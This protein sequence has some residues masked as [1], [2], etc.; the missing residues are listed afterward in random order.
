MIQYLLSK[1]DYH[2]LMWSMLSVLSIAIA[3]FYKFQ[4]D[5]HGYPMTWPVQSIPSI[6]AFHIAGPPPADFALQT[7]P[8]LRPQTWQHR[9]TSDDIGWHR[10][11]SDDV[12]WHRMTSDD[13]GWHGHQPTAH[14]HGALISIVSILGCSTW[15][16]PHSSSS[17]IL[18]FHSFHICFHS[19]L[20][21]WLL[22]R[23]VMVFWI[24]AN[25][26]NSASAWSSFV[27]IAQKSRSTNILSW[28]KNPSLSLSLSI[29][30]A[31]LWLSTVARIL[32][33]DKKLG[34]TSN[35]EKYR[36]M[37]YLLN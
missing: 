27:D 16:N 34:P 2:N 1:N 9:M 37:I 25:L 18:S 33:V 14:W 8:T 6:P 24:S 10:M 23:I 35:Y 11:T 22:W 15:T 5:T 20:K 4:W 31:A 7:S 32:G 28:K 3:T 26:H 19:L 21:S 17:Y 13:I 36:K 12:G 29:W 30:S